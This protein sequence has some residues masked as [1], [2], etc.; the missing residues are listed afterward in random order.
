MEL[1]TPT[2]CLQILQ[3]VHRCI[4]KYCRICQY[5]QDKRLKRT[6]RVTIANRICVLEKI[7]YLI[8]CFNKKLNCFNYKKY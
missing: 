7:V 2:P 1:V 4:S 3:T 5:L 6:T 8:T